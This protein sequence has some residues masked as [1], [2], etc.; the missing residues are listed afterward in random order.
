[1]I[2]VTLHIFPKDF[3]ENLEYHNHSKHMLLQNVCG[4]YK[5][6]TWRINT[7][8]P[9]KVYRFPYDRNGENP[10][11]SQNGQVVNGQLEYVEITNYQTG[12]WKCLHPA[13]IHTITAQKNTQR[14]VSFVIKSKLEINTDRFI[15]SPEPR[16][17]IPT[18]QSEM[19]I[20][21]ERENIW[22]YVINSVNK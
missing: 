20:G 10:D 22:R 19:I 3:K 15:L 1:M 16:L 17:N 13:T 11:N 8:K 6:T 7:S 5:H 12:N 21:E 9:G 14:I 4:E 18:L 2:N